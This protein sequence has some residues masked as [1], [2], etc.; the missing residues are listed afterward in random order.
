MECAFWVGLGV[1]MWG[2]GYAGDEPELV[3]ELTTWAADLEVVDERG[4]IHSFGGE[5]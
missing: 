1:S 2:W 4:D 3:L 5:Q